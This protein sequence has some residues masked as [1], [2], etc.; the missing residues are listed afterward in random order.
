[1][2]LKMTELEQTLQKLLLCCSNEPETQ[3]STFFFETLQGNISYLIPILQ[4]INILQ[5]HDE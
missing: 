5:S 3:K 4:Y 2:D 1:M